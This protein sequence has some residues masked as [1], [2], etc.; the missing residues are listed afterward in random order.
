MTCICCIHK[1]RSYKQNKWLTVK[2]LCLKWWYNVFQYA[3]ESFHVTE[4]LFWLDYPFEPSD[5]AIG[6][7]FGMGT[8]GWMIGKRPLPTLH[9]HRESTNIHIFTACRP[10]MEC[11]RHTD[12]R[13]HGHTHAYG[14]GPSRWAMWH[15]LHLI[16]S[17]FQA[18]PLQNA[19]VRRWAGKRTSQWQGKKLSQKVKHGQ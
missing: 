1:K 15:G 14:K 6:G 10:V 9:K 13:T 17:G 16:Q 4:E 2:W 18:Y 3:C 8:R 5:L 7:N 19:W 12:T 11:K